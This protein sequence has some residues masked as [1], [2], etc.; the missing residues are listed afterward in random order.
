MGT[1]ALLQPLLDVSGTAGRGSE[2]NPSDLRTGTSPSPA[3]ELS[4]PDKNLNLS[5]SS[6]LSSS[7]IRKPSSS[8]KS[9]F[10]SRCKP[11]RV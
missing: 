9:C 1:D 6:S 2:I 3:R 8:R 11:A 7:F 5:Y 10:L 4:C